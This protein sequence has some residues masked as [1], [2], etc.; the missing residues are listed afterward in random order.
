MIS[1]KDK[2]Q[3]IVSKTSFSKERPKSKMHKKINYSNFK[4]VSEFKSTTCLVKKTKIPKK[5]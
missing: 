1:A 2:E 4:V 5:K 3:S